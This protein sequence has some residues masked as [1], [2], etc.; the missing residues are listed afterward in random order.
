MILNFLSIEHKTPTTFIARLSTSFFDNLSLNTFGDFPLAFVSYCVDILPLSSTT[1]SRWRKS[2]TQSCIFVTS[3]F[4]LTWYRV[5]TGLIA[6]P[7]NENQKNITWKFT[8]SL[9]IIIINMSSSIGIFNDL[10]KIKFFTLLGDGDLKWN[11][12]NSYAI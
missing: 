10:L 9:Y 11:K 7:M 4:D 12:I 1:V 3:I 8:C 5:L 6:I 2:V